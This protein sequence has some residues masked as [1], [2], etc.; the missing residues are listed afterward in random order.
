MELYTDGKK[1]IISFHYDTAL[2]E[3]VKTLPD[4]SFDPQTKN[5]TLP[6]N[7]E[8]FYA[9]RKAFPNAEASFSILS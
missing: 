7:L 3:K 6:L 1:L 2:V 5:W 8:S 9:F 4:R